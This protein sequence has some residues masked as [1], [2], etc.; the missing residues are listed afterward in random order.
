MRENIYIARDIFFRIKAPVPAVVI[1][2]EN[3][4]ASFICKAQHRAKTQNG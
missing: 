1:V 3:I 2:N 4:F